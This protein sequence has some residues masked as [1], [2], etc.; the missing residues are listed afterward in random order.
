MGQQK[1]IPTDIPTDLHPGMGFEVQGMGFFGTAEASPYT[2]SGCPVRHDGKAGFGMPGG[3]A[4]TS[5]WLTFDNS[6]LALS[7]TY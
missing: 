3:K 7:N 4:W 5:N 1:Y 2:K 6:H